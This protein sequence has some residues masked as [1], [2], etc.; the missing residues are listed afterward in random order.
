MG[1]QIEIGASE[2]QRLWEKTLAAVPDEFDFV[3]RTYNDG[4]PKGS[5][6]FLCYGR[7]SNR[8]MLKRYGFCIP[9]NKYNYL[10]IKLR[11]EPNDQD[12]AY[13]K[14]VLR[15]FFS[16]DDPD[17]DKKAMDISSRHF[18]VYFQKLNTKVLKFIKILTFNVHEDDISCIVET[19]SLSLEYI[20]LQRLKKV[21]EE[22]LE[23]FPTT[24]KEDSRIMKE[25][26]H[27]LTGN[28]FFALV[29]RSEMK[30]ILTNQINLIKI[31]LHI[32]ERLMKGL[33]LDFAV[34]R[35]FELESK[36]E[37]VVNR[38]MIDNYLTSLKRGLEKNQAA[39]LGMHGTESEAT[40]LR[41]LEQQRDLRLELPKVAYRQFEVRGYDKM[42]ERIL[43]APL[44][45]SQSSN[46]KEL[47]GKLRLIKDQL[48]EQVK[49]NTLE[50]EERKLTDM[51]KYLSEGDSSYEEGSSYYDEEDDEKGS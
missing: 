35:V 39:Y 40:R 36:K 3:I 48:Q 42:I 5:Q 24:V 23:S 11:L 44:K 28:K 16:I 21:Y 29:Y 50:E 34:T 41:L 43:E 10:Y 32:L 31:V 12:F 6:V 9:H 46:N 47:E 13:R 26:A 25:D 38:M 18:R 33:T 51:D 19:R 17:H 45:S 49:Q 37:F 20:S 1:E 4:F 27:K 2:A 15:K 30:K 8:D 7:M 14:Y 22:F